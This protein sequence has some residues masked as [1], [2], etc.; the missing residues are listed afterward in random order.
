[1]SNYFENC[2][3]MAE[4]KAEYRRLAM[5]NHPDRGGDAEV[6]KAINNAYEAAFKR[7]ESA[8]PTRP[9]TNTDDSKKNATEAPGAFIAIIDKL[10]RLDG[11]VVELCGEWLWISGDTRRHKDA[12]KSAGC[13]W[14]VGKSMW[15][16]RPFWA[17]HHGKSKA[18][19]SDIRTK[20]GSQTFSRGYESRAVAAIEA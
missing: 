18:T 12:L 13:Y 11:L 1:M 20:Y 16:W 3:T 2:T 6:M 4:L 9:N 15:Y 14:S 5:A 7:I 17:A 10:I 8:Q 19:M